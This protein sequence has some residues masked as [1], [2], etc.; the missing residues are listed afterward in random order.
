MTLRD[1]MGPEAPDLPITSLAFASAQVEPGALFF[2]VPG[3]SADGH[4]FAPEAVARGAAAL[5]CERP[6][7]LGVPEVLVPAVRAAMGPVAARFHGDPTKEL[8]VV[9][10]TGTNGKTTTAYLVRAV[11]EAAGVRCGL[12]GTV[13]SVIGGREEPVERTTPEAIDLQRSFRRMVDAGDRACALE[14]SSHALELGRAD[15]IRFA[16]RVFTNLSQDHLDFHP[17]MEH[18]FLAKR[19]LFEVA[20]GD[21]GV[22][23]VNVDDGWGRRL[24]ADLEGVV[25]Y[26]IE[27]PA[28]LRARE[29]RFG[30]EGSG[31]RVDTPDGSAEVTTRLPGHFNVLNALA[32]IGAARALDVELAVAARALAE[33]RRVPGRMEPVEEGQDFAVL[34][35]YAHTPEALE[36]VLPAARELCR[37]RLHVVFGAGGDRDRTK[38]PLM[39]R[40]AR[41][42]ADRVVV[43]SD[44]P[45]SE[46]PEAIVDEVLVGSGTDV[47]HDVDRRRAIAR[48]LAGA[49]PGDVVVIAG[50]GH[51][52][53]QE[54][55]DGRK[56]PFDDVTVAREVLRGA[57]AATGPRAAAASQLR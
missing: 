43:T 8:R 41:A 12:L 23:V 28:E 24:A 7:G 29:V 54:F 32:A 20:G 52:Q 31:F 50:K 26:A 38:R 21:P 40:V 47:E 18:Y 39:G 19:R 57:D 14:V 45:R 6:L 3:F 16:C 33:A 30:P 1:L 22:S 35:D 10:I 4:D 15:G 11:L 27:R 25:T 17:S 9:G 42:L 48:A 46:D 56:E 34:V 2:C 55:A 49:G 13:T 5:V 53:G 44:N 37:G 51:E 36:N